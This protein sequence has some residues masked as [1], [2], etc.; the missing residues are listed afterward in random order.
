MTGFKSMAFRAL[1]ILICSGCCLIRDCSASKGY[2]VWA[3]D[4]GNSLAGQTALGVRG[5]YVWIF[6]SD[7]IAVQL[8]SSLFGTTT[9]TNAAPL[10]CTPGTLVGPCDI[11]DIFPPTLQDG[12]GNLLSSLSNFGRLHGVIADPQNLYVVANMFTPQVSLFRFAMVSFARTQCQLT[13]AIM[14]RSLSLQGAF[15]GVIDV[16]TREAI[17]L[18][19]ATQYTFTT[20]TGTSVPSRSVH[21][22][23]W[24]EKNGEYILINNLDGKAIERINVSRNA[25]GK[26]T[27]LQFDRSAGLGLGK[28]MAVAASAEVYTGT[29]AFGRALMGSVIGD[30]GNANLGNLTPAGACKEDGCSG[31]AI[32]PTAPAAVAPTMCPFVPLPVRNRTFTLRWVAGVCSWRTLPKHP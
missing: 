16:E 3:S 24:D 23:F 18:F 29:N 20:T 12:A 30:Y 5:S 21:M 28:D 8:A 25:Q 1:L 6:D 14:R 7:D 13:Q 17:A 19:R 4:Q 9:T 2:E 32:V 31:A 22:S 15:V 26:I 10:P 27:N 11:L